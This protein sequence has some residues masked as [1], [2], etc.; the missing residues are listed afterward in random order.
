MPCGGPQDDG[1]VGSSVPVEMTHAMNVPKLPANIS[2]RQDQDKE[3]DAA[4]AH[5]S[6]G[7]GEM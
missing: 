3:K 2:Q 5:E 7:S 4:T 1:T 6:R